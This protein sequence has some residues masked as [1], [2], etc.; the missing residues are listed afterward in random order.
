MKVFATALINNNTH[1]YK[2]HVKLALRKDGRIA[3]ITPDAAVFDSHL[4]AANDM[5]DAQFIAQ[6]HPNRHVYS[7]MNMVAQA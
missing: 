7:N 4:P 6:H 3:C 2:G 1:N 5:A